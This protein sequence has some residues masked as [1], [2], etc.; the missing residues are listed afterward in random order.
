VPIFPPG[1]HRR[2]PSRYMPREA[3]E[4]Q[5]EA[6][7]LWASSAPRLH[8]EAAPAGAAKVT[9]LAHYNRGYGS[10]GCQDDKSAK[11]A[12]FQVICHYT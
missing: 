12:L 8:K 6:F 9:G 1:L 2:D 11:P 3:T 5:H 10:Q 4:R 7:G